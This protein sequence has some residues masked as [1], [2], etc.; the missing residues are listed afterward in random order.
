M[1]VKPYTASEKRQMLAGNA[2]LDV[3]IY[4][5]VSDQEIH[6]IWK[7]MTEGMEE[8]DI[9]SLEEFIKE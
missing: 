1:R 3:S 2:G 4:D 6:E 7:R 9:E 8:L 5:N